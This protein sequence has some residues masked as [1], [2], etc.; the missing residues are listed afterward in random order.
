MLN[1]FSLRD[2]WGYEDAAHR[3]VRADEV[4]E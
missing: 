2:M 1:D 3:V 4:I